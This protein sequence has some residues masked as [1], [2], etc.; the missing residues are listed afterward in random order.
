MPQLKKEKYMRIFTTGYPTDS[1]DPVLFQMQELAAISSIE[2]SQ[3]LLLPNYDCKHKSKQL[4]I[5]Q[6]HIFM[7]KELFN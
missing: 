7:K 2:M 1:S 6:L 3:S 4:I 5:I